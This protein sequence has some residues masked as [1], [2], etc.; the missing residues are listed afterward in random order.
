MKQS[1][2]STAAARQSVPATLVDVLWLTVT[3]AVVA[4]L[5]HVAYAEFRF[6]VLH[7]FTW[8]NREFAWLALAGYL[9]CFLVLAI[10]VAGLSTMLRRWVGLRA[11]VAAFASL[12]AFA[13]VLLYQG[14]HPLA[15]VALALGVGWQFGAVVA[16]A[17]ARWMRRARMT[18]AA[19][20]VA[21]GVAGFIPIARL[22][23][24]ES[25]M[26]SHLPQSSPE[27]PNIILLIMD[28]VRATNLS[29]YGYER[30]TTPVLD[31]LARESSV[32]DRA[33]SVA[34]WTAPSHA[35]MMTG[36][37]ASQTGADYLSSM[38]DSLKTVA[39]M[40]GQHGYATGGFM[41]NAGYAGYQ[42]GISRGFAH[43]EDFPFTFGQAIWSTTL[44]QTGSGSLVLESLKNGE[45]WKLRRAITHPNL[46]TVIVRKHEPRT[47]ADIVRHF[48]AWRDGVQER[49][50]FAMLNFMDAHA[51]YDPADGFRTRFNGGKKEMDRYDGAIAY[52]DSVI[53]SIIERLQVRGDLDRTILIVT[54][55]HGE[56]FGEHGLDGHGNSLYL[57]LLHVPLLVRAPGRAPAGTRVQS[58]VSL[59][60]LAA[61]LVDF[62]GASP[63]SI[64]GTS[65]AVT[66]RSGNTAGLS[67]ALSEIAPAINPGPKNLTARGPM[68]SV[69]D[70]AWH[71]MRFGDGVEELYAWR[72]DSAEVNNLARSPAGIAE[73]KRKRDFIAKTLGIHWPG[74]RVGRY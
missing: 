71:Y 17:P 69:I 68:K 65:L 19:G 29:L 23:L 37:W 54:A 49:P 67:P 41:A 46:R 18:A 14:I 31:R 51:P 61:T 11:V 57:P 44:A 64:P 22:R 13:I 9:S 48:F 30:P 43:Y 6:R 32:F 1:A 55:D 15:Q 20:T 58:I 63:G 52:E 72:T 66:W 45:L 42:L 59:R 70:S 40:L 56:Q 7:T 60:D 62:A 53:G 39:D 10:P 34:P 4:S 73:S 3:G 5:V 8:T 35:S 36:Q 24:G 47:A 16:A 74:T 21:L 2:A 50:Y 25:W 27:A 26:R 38:Y 33:F 12:T 28:T